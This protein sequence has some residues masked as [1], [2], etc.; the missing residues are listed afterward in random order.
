VDLKELNRESFGDVN[1]QKLEVVEK[2]SELDRL[3]D[4]VLAENQRNERIQ[5]LA[6]LKEVN[7]RQE[8]MIKQKSKVRWLECRI[9]TP[10][11]FHS[12]INWKKSKNTFIGLAVQ[13]LW[14][15]DPLVIKEEV[16]RFF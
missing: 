7:I 5:M 4:E 16:R 2:I 12:R 1:K 9:R 8:S 10:I 14:C 13:D 11:F 3:D 15:E 6:Q